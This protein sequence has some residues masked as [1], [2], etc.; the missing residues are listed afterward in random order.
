MTSA[1]YTN[2]PQKAMDCRNGFLSKDFNIA[3][4]DRFLYFLSFL[5]FLSLHLKKGIHLA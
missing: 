1:L 4:G 5:F 3:T 2:A